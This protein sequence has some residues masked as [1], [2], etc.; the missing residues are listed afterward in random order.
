MKNIRRIFIESLNQDVR[1]IPKVS[2]HLMIFKKKKSAYLSHKILKK[3]DLI[4]QISKIYKILFRKM[5]THRNIRTPRYRIHIRIIFLCVCYQVIKSCEHDYLCHF[6]GYEMRKQDKGPAV[7]SY[8]P[9]GPGLWC[10]SWSQFCELW[11]GKKNRIIWTIPGTM[12]IN[13]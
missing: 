6:T 8:T 11:A 9:Q 1:I 4:T 13:E 3:S 12:H 2:L 5:F 10:H 7:M